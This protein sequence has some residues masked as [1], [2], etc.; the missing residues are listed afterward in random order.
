MQ[1]HQSMIYSHQKC[2]NK[3]VAWPLRHWFP[4]TWSISPRWSCWW[5]PVAWGN[6][7]R[8][9]SGEESPP[10]GS[11]HLRHEPWWCSHPEIWSASSR[12]SPDGGDEDTKAKQTPAIDLFAT[13]T[14]AARQF[15]HFFLGIWAYTQTLFHHVLHIA[16]EG[17][18]FSSIQQLHKGLNAGSPHD[19][20]I[21]HRLGVYQPLVDR[22][23]T[24]TTCEGILALVVYG[25]AGN[26]TWHPR[27]W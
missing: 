16:E 13:K 14:S 24:T 5:S 26:L 27:I 17:T 9:T 25:D 2:K 11:C 22:Q 23:I 21:G 20:R 6:S 7:P 12:N 15:F 10:R 3:K 4:Q 19:A 1:N 18:I 8:R